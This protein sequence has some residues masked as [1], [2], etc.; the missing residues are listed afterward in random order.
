MEM[1]DFRRSE[2]VRDIK[3]AITTLMIINNLDKLQD[4]LAQMLWFKFDLI[5][6]F[7][8]RRVC[9]IIIVVYYYTFFT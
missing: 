3:F 9:K 6:N 8:K 7:L 2:W 4:D 5:N 1:F